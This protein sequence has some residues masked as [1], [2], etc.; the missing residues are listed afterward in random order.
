MAYTPLAEAESFDP[1]KEKELYAS[2]YPTAG[3]A[4]NPETGNAV[5][6]EQQGLLEQSREAEEAEAEQQQARSAGGMSPGLASVLGA[7]GSMLRTSGWQSQPLSYAQRLG[8]A[9]PAGMQAYYQQ[10]AYNQEAE[11][12][13]NKAETERAKAES[14]SED[15][16][17]FRQ[18]LTSSDLDPGWYNIFMG[19]YH[20]L[21]KNFMS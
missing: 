6:P 15:R 1:E 19:V 12:A 4:V 13:Y 14:A 2:L 11:E 3:V 20:L 7:A 17:A 21:L 8:Y 16:E 5:N 10:G 9:I 18:A